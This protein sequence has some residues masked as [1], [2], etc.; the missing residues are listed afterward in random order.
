MKRLI[1]LGILGLLLSGCK[2]YTK[3]GGSREH[4]II[5]FTPDNKQQTFDII[6]PGNIIAF[7]AK[8]HSILAYRD[9]NGKVQ[10]IPLVGNNCWIY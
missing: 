9:E 4:E 1:G 10:I 8:G 3:S 2:G 5:C 7:V 6:V